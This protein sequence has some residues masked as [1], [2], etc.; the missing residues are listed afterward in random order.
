MCI[1]A[2]ACVLPPQ[3]P[4]PPLQLC[5]CCLLCQTHPHIHMCMHPH[6]TNIHTRPK[7]MQWL[8]SVTSYLNISKSGICSIMHAPDQQCGEAVASYV[9][10]VLSS[11][12]A[13]CQITLALNSRT[14]THFSAF[15]CGRRRSWLGMI[16]F[17]ICRCCI[18]PAPR[19]RGPSMP[20]VLT[21]DQCCSLCNHAEC[22]SGVDARVCDKV[23]RHQ[24]HASNE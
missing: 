3:P 20:T 4:P 12:D 15:K 19:R 6:C 14:Q 5:L 13:M 10:Q 1:E 21:S 7:L 8:P 17:R 24:Y 2:F 18:M 9:S 22:G 11:R 16:L 23:G